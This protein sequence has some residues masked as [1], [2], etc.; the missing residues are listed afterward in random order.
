MVHNFDT[1]TNIFL[2]SKIVFNTPPVFAEKSQHLSKRALFLF[3]RRALRYI[4]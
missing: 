1:I 2:Y 4:Q 3:F